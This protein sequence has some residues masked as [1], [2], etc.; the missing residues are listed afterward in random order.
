MLAILRMSLLKNDIKKLQL[1][2]TFSVREN[3]S[4]E[5]HPKNT[6]KRN[7]AVS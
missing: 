4:S 6:D 2:G 5:K 1:S 7:M 3:T